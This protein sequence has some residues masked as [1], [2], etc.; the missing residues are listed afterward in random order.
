MTTLFLSD[1]HLADAQ[2]G[3]TRRFLDF[4]RGPARE[5]QAIYILGDLFEYWA[6]DDDLEETF[7][8][9]HCAALREL[10]SAG[11]RIFFMAGNRDFLAGDGF[12]RAAGLSLLPEPAVIE[13]D[14]VPTLLLHGDTLCTDD[15]AYQAFRSE[16]RSPDWKQAFLSLPLAQRKARIEALRRESEAQKQSKPWDI[17]DVNPDAVSRTLT[18]HRCQ[19]LIHGHT[20]RPACHRLEIDGRPCE[21]WVLPDWDAAGGYLACGQDGCRL[22]P[23]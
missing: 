12:A 3:I 23:L 22:V 16:V 2:P 21:R 13:L 18:F 10:A 17:M 11:V 7:V 8:A 4:L 9:G 19:R 5:A 15:A 20:H 14:G 6:G 1:L